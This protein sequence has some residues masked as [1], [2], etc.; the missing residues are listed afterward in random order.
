M[1]KIGDKVGNSVITSIESVPVSRP[2][3]FQVGDNI[4]TT[5]KE[6][7]KALLFGS[8]SATPDGPCGLQVCDPLDNKWLKNI[9]CNNMKQAQNR[10]KAFQVMQYP[11][12]RLRFRVLGKRGVVRSM[13]DVEDGDLYPGTGPGR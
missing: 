3:P 7:E 6:T 12:L 1:A 9:L 13:F 2:I 5:D 8:T 4:V 10:A 11:T